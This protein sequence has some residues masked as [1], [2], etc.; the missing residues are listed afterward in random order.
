MLPKSLPYLKNRQRENHDFV[1]L[2]A[3]SI[4]AILKRWEH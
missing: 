2:G 3:V 1:S 4:K